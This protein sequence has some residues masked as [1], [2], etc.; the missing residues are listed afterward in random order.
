MKGIF[1]ATAVVLLFGKNPVAAQQVLPK[2]D[3]QTYLDS[4]KHLL[5]TSTSDSVKANTNFFLSDYWRFKDTTKS[6]QYLEDGKAYIYRNGKFDSQHPF[7][8]GLYFFYEGQFYFNWNARLAADAYLKADSI[9]EKMEREDAYKLRAA[10][11]YNYAIMVRPE[12]G[13]DFLI[14]TLLNLSIP[15]I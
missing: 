15:L 7:L 1:L 8:Q 12:K 2:V 6:R 10:A 13:D 4:L 9:F 3:E 14:N 11:R 5:L